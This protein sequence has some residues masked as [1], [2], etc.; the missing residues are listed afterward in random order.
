MI[1]R[2][3]IKRR[4]IERKTVRGRQLDELEKSVEIKLNTKVPEKWLIVDT[5][6]GE[7]YRHNGNRL[8]IVTQ[9]NLITEGLIVLRQCLKELM[10]Q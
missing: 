9:R 7:V 8:K 5:E 10:G 4:K 1:L 2:D 6:T 3:I